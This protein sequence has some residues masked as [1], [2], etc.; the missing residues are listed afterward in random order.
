M[1]EQ[2]IATAGIWYFVA[3]AAAFAAV[4]VEQAGAARSPDEDSERKGAA[5][6]V[7]MLASLFTPGLLLMHG[8]FLTAAVDTL[9]RIWIMAAAVAAILLGSILG[10]IFGAVARGAAPTMRKLALPLGLAALALT[11]FATSPSIVALVNGLQDGVLEL[12]V[13]PV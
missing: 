7:L 11:L 9:L 2:L 12:P 10:A 13:H 3:C 5:A 8:F 4:F 1:P 6:L